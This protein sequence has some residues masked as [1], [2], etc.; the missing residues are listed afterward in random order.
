MTTL[1]APVTGLLDHE[2]V[3]ADFPIL[4]RTVR[5][6]MQ[7]ERALKLLCELQGLKSH[8]VNNIIR[9]KFGYIVSCQRYGAQKKAGEAQADDIELLLQLYA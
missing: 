1:S 2:A 6:M 8:E 7:Y 5:G 4:S 3:A 9:A